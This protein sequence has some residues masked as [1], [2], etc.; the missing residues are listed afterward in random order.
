MGTQGGWEVVE[1]VAYFATKMKERAFR[2]ARERVWPFSPSGTTA[3]A[4]SL[5]ADDATDFD[6]CYF[7]E[8]CAPGVIAL[9]SDVSNRNKQSRR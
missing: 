6:I 9:C 5:A 1:E 4:A 3:G 8:S 7:L 2:K